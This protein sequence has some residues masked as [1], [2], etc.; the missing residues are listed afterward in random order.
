MDNVRRACNRYSHKPGRLEKQDEKEHALPL[1]CNPRAL[2]RLSWSV[3]QIKQTALQTTAL[4]FHAQ[5]VGAQL[6]HLTYHIAI[7]IMF[8]LNIQ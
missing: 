1:T 3:A 2:E 5:V 6:H 7:G 4:T 8:H